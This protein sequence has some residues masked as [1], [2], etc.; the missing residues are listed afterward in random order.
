MTT[1]DW[2]GK[3][4]DE[5]K[6]EIGS[7]LDSILNRRSIEA[8]Y[9]QQARRLGFA[10]GQDWGLVRTTLAAAR[11]LDPDSFIRWGREQRCYTLTYSEVLPGIV[12]AI[13]IEGT[14]LA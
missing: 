14:L 5:I 7:L 12:Q 13:H 3:T 2:S 6:R 9:E 11:V 4:P 8:P 1:E 10:L